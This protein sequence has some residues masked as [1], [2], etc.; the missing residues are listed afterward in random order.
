M[1]KIDLLRLFSVGDATELVI[2]QAF[3]VLTDALAG[4]HFRDAY[5]ATDVGVADML[6]SSAAARDATDAAAEQLNS[7]WPPYC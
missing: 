3:A 7:A 6:V 4:H 1:P 2:S 5:A